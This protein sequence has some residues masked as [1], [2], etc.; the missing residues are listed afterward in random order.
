ML[1][2]LCILT[3]LLVVFA[4]NPP[5]NHKRVPINTVQTSNA[6]A[7][8]GQTFETEND[9]PTCSPES[10]N[11]IAFI[12][13]SNKIVVCQDEQWSD[14]NLTD[15]DSESQFNTYLNQAALPA[16]DS[17]R[18]NTIAYV[19]DSSVIMECKDQQWSEAKGSGGDEGRTYRIYE[20]QDLAGECNGDREGEFNFITSEKKFIH[21]QD[22]MWTDVDISGEDGTQISEAWR[23]VW[24]ANVQST[25]RI[26]NILTVYNNTD[27]AGVPN[28]AKA[29]NE[30]CRLGSSGSGFIVG[31]DIIATNAHVANTWKTRSLASI[32]LSCRFNEAAALE[33]QELAFNRIFDHCVIPELP[34]PNVTTV[35]DVNAQTPAPLLT[36]IDNNQILPS[37]DEFLDDIIILCYDVE[38]R[39]DL[40]ADIPFATI[41]LRVSNQIEY[42]EGELN[43][44][45]SRSLEIDFTRSTASI[46]PL[47]GL[48]QLSVLYPNAQGHIDL[49]SPSSPVSN[50]DMS[51]GG[52]DDLALLQAPTGQ[53]TPVTLSQQDFSPDGVSMDGARLN[54]DVL[55]I[56]Y[57][58][59]DSYAHFVTGH[60]NQA[61]RFDVF[62]PFA[63]FRS[64][65]YVSDDRVLYMYDLVSGGGSSGSA[66]FNLAGEVIGYNFA[67]DTPAADT[68]FA[69]GLQVLHLR[70]LLAAPR[71]WIVPNTMPFLVRVP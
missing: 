70:N 3:L 44:V 41:N 11:E 26:S 57:S 42:P 1:E 65:F 46:N 68:D 34:D 12:N 39:A 52:S 25:V 55:L 38:N 20:T 60:L 8:F 5:A 31:Q 24:Q 36:L 71:N 59:G 23:E 37:D 56:G 53:R 58:R 13:S 50:L 43:P 69:Y 9:L 2:K 10:K 45:A 51:V 18:E 28:A 4:C 61:V 47:L 62:E 14:I 22:N 66:I 35:V 49:N 21:C 32:Y 15:T 33:T 19:F 63:F 40:A 64:G 30:R 67:G 16:C 48:A 29:G 27:A 6:Q 54:E 17:S 7:G